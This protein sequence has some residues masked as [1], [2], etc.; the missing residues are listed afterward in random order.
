MINRDVKE[1]KK[2]ITNLLLECTRG[3]LR[4]QWKIIINSRENF[5]YSW[6]GVSNS[7][8]PGLL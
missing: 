1:S 2:I 5:Y 4:S 7:N 8:I 6:P 3:S